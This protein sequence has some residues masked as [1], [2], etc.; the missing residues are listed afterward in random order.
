MPA[1]YQSSWQEYTG[2]FFVFFVFIFKKQEKIK[3][4]E[5]YF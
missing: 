3:N 4:L 1:E 2:L 5:C